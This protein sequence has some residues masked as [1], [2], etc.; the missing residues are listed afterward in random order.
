MI[1]NIV[2][3]I[4][5]LANVIISADICNGCG[6]CYHIRYSGLSGAPSPGVDFRT[7]PK[8]PFPG[9]CRHFACRWIPWSSSPR[10][11]LLRV[12]IVI[13]YISA[14]PFQIIVNKQVTRFCL[15]S[16]FGPGTLSKVLPK[17]TFFLPF[18]HQKIVILF[19]YVKLNT[20]LCNGLR[21]GPQPIPATY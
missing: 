16:F 20:Y 8:R 14:K 12:F 5:S 1:L 18:D 4:S 2:Y 7:S 9:L 13:R 17:R 19:V 21:L 11:S 6:L 3:N 15:F 10:N